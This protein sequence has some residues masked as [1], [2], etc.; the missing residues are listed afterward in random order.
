MICLYIAVWIKGQ[1]L[2]QRRIETQI[3]LILRKQQEIRRSITE[4]FSLRNFL[5]GQAN[6]TRWRS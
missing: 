1:E 2:W 5:Q 6:I 4:S 3:F